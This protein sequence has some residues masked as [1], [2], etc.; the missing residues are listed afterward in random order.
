MEDVARDQEEE[1]IRTE[2]LLQHIANKTRLGHGGQ[3]RHDV[4]HFIFFMPNPNTGPRIL[5]ICFNEKL[6]ENEKRIIQD[7][8]PGLVMAH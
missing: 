8:F 5:H 7:M 1:E 6:S 3:L 4:N 2:V